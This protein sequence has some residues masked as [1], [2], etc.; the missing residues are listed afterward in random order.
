M[1][2]DDDGGWR[3]RNKIMHCLLSLEGTLHRDPN[4]EQGRR[5]EEFGKPFIGVHFFVSFS[6]VDQYESVPLAARHEGTALPCS[7][8]SGS[9][10]NL[11]TVRLKPEY[12][13]YMA[14]L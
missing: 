8:L 5:Y 2:T 12:R 3:E 14:I 6:K 11:K 1:R 10:N 9:Y 13:Y 7:R 4:E